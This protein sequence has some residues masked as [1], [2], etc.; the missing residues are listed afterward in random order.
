M[1]A[2]APPTESQLRYLRVLAARTAST[3]ASPAS[4]LQ[5]SREIDRLKHLA[6]VPHDRRAET[7][8]EAPLPY[9]TAVSEEEL[10]GFGATR[11]WRSQRPPIVPVRAYGSEVGRV[12]LARYAA[13]EE[14]RVLYAT[15][16]TAGQTVIDSPARSGGRRYVVEKLTS[17]DG[18]EALAA[19]VGD[20][21]A[22]ARQLDAVPMCQ[23]ALAEALGI[24]SRDA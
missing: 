11:S 23:R 2:A 12:E 20:Y 16:S 15:G 19:L 3:F 24:G 1:S 14:E 4:R 17:Q 8:D 10:T 13:G 7:R 18:P 5:A 22:R 6:P 21:L 9:A